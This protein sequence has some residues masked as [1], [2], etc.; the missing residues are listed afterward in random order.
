[1]MYVIIYSSKAAELGFNVKTHVTAHGKMVLNEKEVLMR[2]DIEGDGLQERVES[3]GGKA[4]GEYETNQFIN[5]G[6]IDN[7]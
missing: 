1:M 4:M 6:D 2:P 7:D 5:K 3:I